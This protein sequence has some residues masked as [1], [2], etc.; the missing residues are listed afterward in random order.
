MTDSAGPGSGG[1]RMLA[2]ESEL[3]ALR[4]EN[5]RLRGLLGL[6]DRCPYW[7]EDRVEADAVHA[8]RV[9]GG[10]ARSVRARC[11]P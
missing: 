5:A 9:P 10:S 1:D 8:S 6:D 7:A 4:A 2:M 11:P 3:A